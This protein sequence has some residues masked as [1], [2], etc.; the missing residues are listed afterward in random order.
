M[1]SMATES[2]RCSFSG[3]AAAVPT[4][5]AASTREAP[6]YEHLAALPLSYR[7]HL[8]RDG[9]ELFVFSRVAE[10]IEL[11][12]FDADGSLNSALT[13]RRSRATAGTDICQVSDPDSVMGSGCTAPGSL[14]QAIG[15]SCQLS[16]DPYAKAIE[17]A[18]TWGAAVFPYSLRDGPDRRDDAD[19]AALGAAQRRAFAF[20]R[21]GGRSTAA[22]SPAR[23]DHLR[24]ARQ[25]SHC[26]A[27]GSAAG[28]ARHL[29]RARPPGHDLLPPA[30]RGD[31][32]GADA[33][34]S[35]RARQEVNPAPPA[36]LLGRPLDRLSPRRTTSMP[37]TRL[38]HTGPWPNSK[39]WSRRCIAPVSR[40]S[41]MWSTTTPP[42]AATWAPM[43]SFRHFDNA[44][45]YHLAEKDR[46]YYMDF[47]GTGNSLNMAH[48]R[49][50]Q[51]VM[52]L[53]PLLGSRDAHRRLSL[54]SG[55]STRPTAL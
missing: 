44:A 46:R 42:R 27:S 11:C 51:L 20:L 48:P 3:L 19:S 23:D 30:T 7:R 26:A 50:L 36:L 37:P 24:D 28:S 33:R 25:G 8:R 17:G 32:R 9:H 29:R 49:P 41:C 40:L 31:G 55:G 38:L 35:V 22:T 45:Y 5:V 34:A 4:V 10:R 12:L 47:T 52:G 43:L 15:A 53:A 14:R 54:R 13:S 39:A 2:L 1:S 6:C 18:V 16:L 21:L